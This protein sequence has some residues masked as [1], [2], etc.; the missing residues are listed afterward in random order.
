[1]KVTFFGTVVKDMTFLWFTW[2]MQIDAN[3]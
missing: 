2:V 3:L 1:L